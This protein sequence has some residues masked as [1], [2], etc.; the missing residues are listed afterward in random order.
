MNWV[1]IVGFVLIAAGIVEFVLFRYVLADKPGIAARMR[2]LMVN[3][4]VNAILGLVLVLIGVT[5][6]S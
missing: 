6:I 2:F 1:T 5:L 4:A 3:A